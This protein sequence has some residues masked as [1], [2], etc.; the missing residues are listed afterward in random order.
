MADVLTDVITATAQLAG[1]L[2]AACSGGT[3]AVPQLLRLGFEELL[4]R[5]EA[6]PPDTP[7][8]EF[9]RNWARSSRDL[10]EDDE[11]LV[12]SYQLTQISRKLSRLKV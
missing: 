10:W 1:E 4:N 12:A 11:P 9:S 8:M 6:L 7:N 2:A 3:P 5:I